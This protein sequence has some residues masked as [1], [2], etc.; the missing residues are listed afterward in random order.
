[1]IDLL[2][3]SGIFVHKIIRHNRKISL[4]KKYLSNNEPSI[5]HKTMPD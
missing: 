1:M 3:D 4:T 2:I 5:Y